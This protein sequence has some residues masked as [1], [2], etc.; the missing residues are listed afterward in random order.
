MGLIHNFPII[1]E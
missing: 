1:D